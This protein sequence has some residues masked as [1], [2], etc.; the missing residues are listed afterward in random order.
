M[1]ELAREYGCGEATVWRA[2][3]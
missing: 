3:Q 2:L 1:A